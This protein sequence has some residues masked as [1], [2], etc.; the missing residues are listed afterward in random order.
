MFDFSFFT[1]N[2]TQNYLKK[3]KNG[4]FMFISHFIAL[5]SAWLFPMILSLSLS[6]SVILFSAFM[7]GTFYDHTSSMRF[8]KIVIF[9]LLI[10]WWILEIIVHISCYGGSWLSR[11]PPHIRWLKKLPCYIFFLIS[12]HN[13]STKYSNSAA[14]LDF[15]TCQL[16]WQFFLFFFW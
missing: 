15:P 7:D 1:L 6:L 14:N 13:K 3:K 11:T 16:P 9:F 4:H 10:H 5:V 8:P 12:F 2:L